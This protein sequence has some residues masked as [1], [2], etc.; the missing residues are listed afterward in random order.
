M[1]FD[2]K[3]IGLW[4][5]GITA[6]GVVGYWLYQYQQTAA[7]NSAAQSAQDAQNQDQAL[8]T[9]EAS[10]VGGGYA[11]ENASV[12]GPTVDTGNNGLQMLINSILNPTTGTVQE[13]P[14]P[15]V[16]TAPVT[17]SPVPVTIAPTGGPVSA[18]VGSG[19]NPLYQSDVTNVHISPA[20]LMTLTSATSLPQ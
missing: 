9:L 8:A 2:W 5:G 17:Q 16:T 1:I 13:T 4:G 6:I 18:P 7:A 10:Q 20:R 12:S 11:N 19:A 3:K 14:T 15:P